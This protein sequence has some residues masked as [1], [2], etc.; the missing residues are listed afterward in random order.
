MASKMGKS[1]KHI[2]QQRCYI[3]QN[4]FTSDDVC[5]LR[6]APAWPGGSH[7]PHLYNVRGIL[8]SNPLVTLVLQGRKNVHQRIDTRPDSNTSPPQPRI[9]FKALAAALHCL[10]YTEHTE[11]GTGQSCVSCHKSWPKMWP[12]T[13]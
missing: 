13:C 4:R 3:L 1:R 9:L 6:S 5:H 2:Q 12:K 10:Y 7:H 8:W 11:Q